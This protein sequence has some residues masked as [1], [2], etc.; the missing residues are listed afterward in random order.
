[1]GRPDDEPEFGRTG[2]QQ[3]GGYRYRRVMRAK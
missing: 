1:M 3:R 2:Y